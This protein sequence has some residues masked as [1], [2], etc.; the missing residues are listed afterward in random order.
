VANANCGFGIAPVHSGHRE[1]TMA[2]R[3]TTEQILVSEQRAA[4]LES[5]PEQLDHLRELGKGVKV[6]TYLPVNPLWST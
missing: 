1:R 4:E 5:F 6:L 2:M 3:E